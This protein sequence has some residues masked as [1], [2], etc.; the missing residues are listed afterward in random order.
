MSPTLLAG[1]VGLA[2]FFTLS[3]L[4]ALGVSAWWRIVRP[5]TLDTSRLL[6]LRLLPAL[7][8]ALL[9]ACLVTPAF[10]RFEPARDAEQP[11][12]V[13]LTVG[14]AGMLVLLAGGAR[15]VRAIFLTRRLR[16]RWLV[17]SS[18]LPSLD[19]AMPARLIDVSYPLVAIVGILR[20]VLV[21]SRKV[22]AACSADEVKLIAA[23]ERAH[24]GARDNLKRLLI[25]GCPDVL[26]WTRTGREIAAAWS[27]A[28]EDAA[29]DAAT[30]GDRRA[31]I[32]LAGV[33]LRVA[34]MAVTGSPAPGL[35]SALVGLSGVERRVRRL[36]ESGPLPTGSRVSLYVALGV[37][38]GALASAAANHQ[39][40]A[41]TYNAAELVVGLGR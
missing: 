25:D 11:G 6:A 39:L 15:I 32:A 35:A 31:R 21:V 4:L 13:L 24:L 12:P 5:R 20:P 17:S 1:L 3:T 16:R 36:A 30:G 10:V 37:V 14:A 9:T 2:S 22:A 41:I 34:R 18:A 23:H 29:D 28:A 40:L 19:G 7:G 26:R 27:A 33:L 38:A 8:G